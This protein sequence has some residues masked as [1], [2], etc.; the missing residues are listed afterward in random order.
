MKNE[1]NNN[2][3]KDNEDL[4]GYKHYPANEDIYSRNKEEIDLDPEDPSHKKAP[5]IDPDAKN[6]KDFKESVDG[7]DLDIP[8]NEE[9]E[10]SMGDG[11]EDEENNFYSLGGDNHDK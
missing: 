8:G 4:P 2:N 6:E 10:S 7:E 5:N 3:K 1:K 9:D 11:H